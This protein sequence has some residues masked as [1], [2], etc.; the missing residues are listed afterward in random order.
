[1]IQKVRVRN[2]NQKESESSEDEKSGGTPKFMP[3]LSGK[4][5]KFSKKD[6]VVQ[7]TGSGWNGTVIMSK[8]TKYSIK[9]GASSSSV[10]LGF[11]P[12]KK[13]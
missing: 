1:V 7:Y 10:M 2:Q 8:A 11:S 3:K 4:S 9:F 12:K 13:N 6:K 5:F